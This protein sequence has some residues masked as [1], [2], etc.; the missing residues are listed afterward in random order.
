M[1]YDE[2]A[3]FIVTPTRSFPFVSNSSSNEGDSR[4][5]GRR[6]TNVRYSANDASDLTYEE[7]GETAVILGWGLDRGSIVLCVRINHQ[8]Y[9]IRPLFKAVITGVLEEP[10][11]E[12][13]IEVVTGYQW[14]NP[15]TIE[16]VTTGGLKAELDGLYQVIP[17]FNGNENKRDFI[18]HGCTDHDLSKKGG[19]DILMEYYG[20]EVSPTESQILFRLTI[21]HPDIVTTVYD[22]EINSTNLLTKT[23]GDERLPDD[24]A[25]FVALQA[26]MPLWFDIEESDC[27]EIIGLYTLWPGY[28]IDSSKNYTA[29]S[30]GFI[31]KTDGTRQD[32]SYTINY[33]DGLYFRLQIVAPGGALN[34][35][36]L[37]ENFSFE[38]GSKMT[39]DLDSNTSTCTAPSSI[40][41]R[42]P[43]T[44]YCR[45][46]KREDQL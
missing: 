22:D 9:A 42:R 34:Y 13:N 2:P 30:R 38:N 26:N 43:Q 5:H 6:I 23:S 37:L 12:G 14:F 16:L 33:F 8:W 19:A 17:R 24:I 35:T 39:F 21:T 45:T 25:W 11:N 1:N 29:I 46:I 20:V 28:F 44:G 10:D 18:S 15:Y 40:E 3:L 7:T 31:H 4:F 27:E 32:R 36:C 41:L